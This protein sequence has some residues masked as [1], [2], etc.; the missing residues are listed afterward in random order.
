M[1]RLRLITMCTVSLVLLLSQLFS[2][3]A[4]AQDSRPDPPRNP[5]I[6]RQS[7]GRLVANWD[8]PASGGISR[9][10]LEYRHKHHGAEDWCRGRDWIVEGT[11][12]TLN[13]DPNAIAILSDDNNIRAMDYMDYKI[14]VRSYIK[15]D[16]HPSDAV[17]ATTMGT[18][19]QPG[20]GCRSS[21][22]PT[23]TPGESGPA[24][25]QLDLFPGNTLPFQEGLALALLSQKPVTCLILAESGHGIYVFSPLG[26]AS[27]IQCQRV[28][29]AGVGIQSIID[30]GFIDAVDVWGNVVPGVEVCFTRS[31]VIDFLDSTT[32]P[33]SHHML[34]AYVADEMSCAGIDRAGTAILMP[35]AP[36]VQPPPA[37]DTGTE[38]DAVTTFDMA[39]F[40]ARQQQLLIADDIYTMMRVRN[41]ELTTNHILN[42]RDSPAGEIIGNYIPYLTTLRALART[43]NWFLVRYD[44]LDGWI[45]AHLV[46]TDGDCDY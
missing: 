8:P 4:Q 13:R 22:G 11:S 24:Q 6:S 5:Q 16:S 17:T 14:L 46:S 7:N 10:W 27:G 18:R 3:T 29:A 32:I 25:S 34:D 23:D 19:T 44:E 40:E 38:T 37:D 39:A 15:S 21:G 30:A 31:G 12:F 42:L 45:T 1:K 43:E 36:A 2:L 33:R 20:K 9:Y 28:D 35:G 26:L 41:C